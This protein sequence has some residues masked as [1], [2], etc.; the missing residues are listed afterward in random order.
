MNNNVV[1]VSIGWNCNSAVF[2]LQNG[3]R[4]TKQ[5]GYNTCPFDEMISN[6]PGIIKCIEN[7]FKYFCDPSYLEVI[8]IPDGIKHMNSN[9]IGEYIIKNTYYNFLFNHESPGHAD[10]YI[11][12]KWKNGK[13]HFV[14]NN[15]SEFIKRYEKRINNFRNYLDDNKNSI[16]FILHRYNTNKH[17][18]SDLINVLNK[19]YPN[20]NYDFYFLEVN[21][22]KNIIKEHLELMGLDCNCDEIIRLN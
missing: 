18:I 22:D 8:K 3:I 17:N 10:L 13:Y 9:G 5:N 11:H 14:E 4:L 1:G 15:F 2:G 6:Y 16:T 20:L 12:Q 19:F 21:Y 7:D